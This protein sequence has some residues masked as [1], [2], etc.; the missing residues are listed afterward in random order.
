MASPS[1]A[2]CRVSIP[3]SATNFFSHHDTETYLLETCTGERVTGYYCE[4]YSVF[5][6]VSHTRGCI[7]FNKK[8]KDAPTQVDRPGDCVIV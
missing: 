1:P 4:L 5:H 6:R 3:E 2:F 8:H 7:Q